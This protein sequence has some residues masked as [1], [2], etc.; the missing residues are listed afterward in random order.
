MFTALKISDA[1][2][3]EISVATLGVL[4]PRCAEGEMSNLVAFLRS[5]IP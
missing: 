5:S 1:Q 3:L 4:C 2:W